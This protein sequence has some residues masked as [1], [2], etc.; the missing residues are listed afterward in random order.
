[1]TK[2]CTLEEWKKYYHKDQRARFLIKDMFSRVRARSG[3]LVYTVMRGEWSKNGTF[4]RCKTCHGLM[5]CGVC[6]AC[7]SCC[8]CAVCGRIRQADGKWRIMAVDSN[9]ISH[10]YCVEC[11]KRVHPEIYKILVAKRGER[12]YGL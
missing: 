11:I 10:T 8:M 6:Q 12:Y 5:I 7:G 2:Q 1:M 9:E 3:D 4:S